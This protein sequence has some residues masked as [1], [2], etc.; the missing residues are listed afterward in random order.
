MRT[1]EKRDKEGIQNHPKPPF[2]SFLFIALAI[3]NAQNRET[4]KICQELTKIFP[5][6]YFF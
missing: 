3:N 5:G 6:F 2:F 4:A 1:K